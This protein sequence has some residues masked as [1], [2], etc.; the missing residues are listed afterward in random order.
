[1]A[2]VFPVCI[3]VVIIMNLK[4]TS[5]CAIGGVMAL[6][7]S[8]RA[9]TGAVSP[10]APVAA[11]VSPSS[12][13][14]GTGDASNPYAVIID[15]NIF[16]LNPKPPPA[17]AEQKPVDLPKV[18]LNG[19]FKVGN[20]VRV[21][22]SI[23]P[24]DTKIPVSYFKLAPS[25]RAT[26]EGDEVLE[27]VRIHPDQQ[28]VDVLVNGTFMTLSMLSNSL[29]SAGGKGASGAAPPGAHRGP[30]AAAA[31]APAAAVA[32]PGGS[33][34]IVVGAD[35]DSSSYGGGVTLAG[36][37][38]P[39][40]GGDNSAVSGGGFSGGVTVGGGGGGGGSSVPSGINTPG[41]Q[42][43]NT[44]FS[45]AQNTGQ[46]TGQTVPPATQV[47]TPAEQAAGLIIYQALHGGGG[48]PL[49]PP[50]AEAAGALGGG[51]PPGVP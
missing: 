29:A 47:A 11:T 37:G 26:G 18:Y 40:I 20:D 1:L 46:N 16:R 24:K 43:A 19:I 4:W 10:N 41:G 32:A 3:Y 7:T 50:V 31:P 12:T 27:L 33:A 25:E 2:G 30:P 17:V 22:F 36:G 38:A 42:L 8:L 39:T 34:A 45:G 23:Q 13:S 51:G 48:P 14:D 21:L 35:R 5:A 49:P 28:E 6:A 44:L 9:L 15:K